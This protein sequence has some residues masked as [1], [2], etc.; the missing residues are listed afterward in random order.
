MSEP[1]RKKI[2][3]SYWLEEDELFFAAAC[4]F[5][6]GRNPIFIIWIVLFLLREE[7]GMSSGGGG[8]GGGGGGRTTGA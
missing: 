5:G 2:A 8:G 3:A 4:G 7:E 1:I 6:E